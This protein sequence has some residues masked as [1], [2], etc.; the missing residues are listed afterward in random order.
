MRVS[1]CKICGTQGPVSYQ[2]LCPQCSSDRQRT[3]IQQLQNRKGGYYQRWRRGYQAAYREGL[4]GKPRKS[5]AE[6]CQL[7]GI[8]RP[9]KLKEVS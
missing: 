6:L 7:Y 8:K 4:I 2:R 5:V 3:L 1:K 9:E